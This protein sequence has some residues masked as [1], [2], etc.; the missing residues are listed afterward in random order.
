MPR[1]IWAMRPNAVSANRRSLSER[2]A[3]ALSSL[4]DGADVGCPKATPP[5]ALATNAPADTATKSLRCMV[6]ITFA[7]LHLHSAK[8]A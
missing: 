6:Y 2:R 8:V 1:S 5:I 4:D 7:I 3:A